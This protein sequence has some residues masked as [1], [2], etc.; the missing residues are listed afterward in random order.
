MVDEPRISNGASSD[1]ALVAAYQAW[2]DGRPAGDPAALEILLTRYYTIIRNDLFGISFFKDAGYLDDVRQQIAITL[3]TEIRSGR[4]K[5]TGDG[6]FRK[7]VYTVA[8]LECLNQDKKHRKQFKPVSEVFPEEPTSLPDDLLPQV[9]PESAD[10]ES[11]DRKLQAVL[12]YLKPEEQKLMQL[13]SINTPYIKILQ[14][15]EFAKYSL[16]YLKHKIYNIRQRIRK[17]YQKGEDKI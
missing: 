8:H 2:L 7:W 12:K 9:T 3:F 13:V 6:S 5:P 15:P 1:E 17:G 10:Y 16:D 11:A 14:E 4:F